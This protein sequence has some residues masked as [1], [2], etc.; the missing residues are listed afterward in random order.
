MPRTRRGNVSKQRSCLICITL[1]LIVNS[2]MIA[3]F[4]PAPELADTKGSWHAG[5]VHAE[6]SL[7]DLQA[8]PK[9]SSARRRR[10][11][12]QNRPPILRTMG[13]RRLRK[14]RSPVSFSS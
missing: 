6:I 13:L 9:T 4:A 1:A 2:K 10:F 8:A 11:H 3:A 12:K 7:R 5:K 14:V